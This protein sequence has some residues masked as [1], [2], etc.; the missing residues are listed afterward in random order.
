[1]GSNEHE[2]V[3]QSNEHVFSGA[4]LRGL[5]QWLED[6]VLQRVPPPLKSN[7]LIPKMT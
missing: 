6:L 5:R 7:E 4:S 1:M 3:I 2:K